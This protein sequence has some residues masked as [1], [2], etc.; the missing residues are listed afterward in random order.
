M[1]AAQRADRLSFFAGA[2]SL[3][4]SHWV[5]ASE[6]IV[7]LTVRAFEETAKG[8]VVGEGER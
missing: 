7:P 6:A 2:R 1:V 3:L 4:V 8:V 5:V